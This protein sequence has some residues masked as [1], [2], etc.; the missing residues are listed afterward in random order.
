MTHIFRL[1]ILALAAVVACG[2]FATLTAEQQ[3]SV[4]REYMLEA[5]IT[6]YRGVGGEIDGI[7]NPVLF[8]LTGQRVRITIVNTDLVLHDIALET[9]KIRSAQILDRGASASV[10]FT[11]KV[12]DTYFCTIPG[13][14]TAGMEGRIEVA[15]APRPR[16][17]GILPEAD[18][19]PLDL[20]FESGTLDGW[21]ADGDAFTV[22]EGGSVPGLS[23][24]IRTG[25]VGRY[26]VTS[27]IAGN[28]RKGTLT[29]KP[30][31]VRAPFASFLVSGGAFNSTRVEL[32]L[33]A[34][35][36]NDKVIYSITGSNRAL[37][38]PAVVDLEP[39][40]GKDIVVRLVDEESGAP[41]AVYL[42]ESPWAHV[43]FDNFRF[44]E[45]RP[46]FPDEIKPS[47]ITTL[48][49]VDHLLHHGLAARDAAPAMTVPKG[50]TV[51]LAA[52]E[53][54]V[55]R[56]IAFALDD[57]GRLWVAEAHT[58]PERAFGDTGKDRILILEDSNG[59]GTLDR[60]KVFIENLNLVSGLEVGFGGVWVGAAPYLLFIPIKNP[61][62]DEAG[63]PRILLDGFGYDDTHETLNSLTWG[64]DGWLYGT[65]GV[66]THSRVGKPG[67]ADIEREPLNAGVWRY[68]PTR[69][70][71]EV[72]AHGSS[73][74]W[75]VDF[76]DYGHAFITACV[77]EHLYH[78]I[79]GARYKRQ[80][81]SHFNRY[82]YDDI[83]T[84]AD[85]VHWVGRQ[86][87][88]AGNNRSGGAGGGHAHAG[89]MIYLGGDAWPAEYRDAIFMNNIHGARTNTDRL[90]R[91]G[92]GYTAAHGP[93]F[94]LTNDAWSQMLNLKYGPDGSVWVIDWY[95]KNQCHSDNEEI[96]QKTL[97]RIFKISNGSNK[98]VSVDLGA[99][100]SERLVELQ[101]NR[102]DWYVR[103]AR[104]ILQE[105]GANVAVHAALK[106]IVET[107]PDVTRKLRAMWALHVTDG[108]AEADAVKLLRHENEYVRS[109]AIQLLLERHHASEVVVREL[110]RLAKEDSS[111]M[112]RLYVASGLQRIEPSQRWGAVAALLA[113]D[114][115]ASDHNLPLMVWYAAEPAV[116]LD[117][118]RALAQTAESKLPQVF[119]F[120]VQRIAAVGTT[121]ALRALTDRLG[122]TEDPAQRI[123]LGAGIV[124]IVGKKQ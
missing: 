118:P 58:Y 115:D 57:R 104:R 124:T 113:R 24:S 50:F 112:V 52:S 5:T 87:P 82:T 99:L 98:R 108:F 106:R 45:L 26:W 36:K 67:A 19:A 74:P 51:T 59:D 90:S 34:G 37:L 21:T 56:P 46:D 91:E 1:R 12:S 4:D 39:Y 86:G 64:P 68:H 8:A 73:N 100:S 80:A 114:E 117:M 81:G 63:E 89:A 110:E 29:S 101:L 23:S 35:D 53:P 9:L 42:K 18:G 14:R 40:L 78:V 15:D 44:H 94:L 31:R 111:A 97:G 60:R 72:F 65:H 13:H 33:A 49:P 32:V 62:T 6:G 77:I 43:N 109:W 30:F 48:P 2:H 121:D 95:D 41:T 84:V 16:P 88:H 75:G 20:G 66:F 92:S 3:T 27:Q 38:R 55:V 103:H 54:A 28:A 116:E 79:Q 119:A 93:D 7:K 102:N 122:R 69:H 120:A 107:H 47:D 105:R 25:H 71:F 83:E 17:E 10:T 76:N 11:A 85:H 123:E 96:H 70:E 22:V 61:K